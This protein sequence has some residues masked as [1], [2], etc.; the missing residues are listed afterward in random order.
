[1]EV[2]HG[3]GKQVGCYNFTYAFIN[4]LPIT[5]SGEANFSMAQTALT[6]GGF[7]QPSAARVLIEQQPNIEKGL[8]QRFLW[9]VPEP[10]HVT[11]D[12]LQR[13][14]SN[15]IDDLGMCNVK[16]NV[17]LESHFKQHIIDIAHLMAVVWSPDK[18]VT[19][20]SLPRRQTGEDSSVVEMS[21]GVFQVKY[22]KVQGDIRTIGCMD[23]LL[24]GEKFPLPV[25]LKL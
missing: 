4:T 8:C 5:V 12:M 9:L 22:D 11:F 17:K 18:R 13:V 10:S 14:D 21:C 25:F 24:S 3:Q 2:V 15:F 20:W 6:V 16:C 1:M 19:K 7:I 23:D